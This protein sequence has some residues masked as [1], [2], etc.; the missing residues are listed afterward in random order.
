MTG[1]PRNRWLRALVILG[2][3]TGIEIPIQ[4]TDYSGGLGVLLIGS[5][6]VVDVTVLAIYFAERPTGGRGPAGDGGPGPEVPKAVRRWRALSAASR[7][8]PRA[9]GRRWLAEAES[10]LFEMA[11]GERRPAGASTCGPRRG[12]WR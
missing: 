5:F 6:V 4:L 3:I 9:A 12:W 1:V 7:L 11:A 2:F 8:M 10:S